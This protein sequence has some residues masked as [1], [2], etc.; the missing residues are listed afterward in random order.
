MPLL[1]SRGE[2][3]D[4]ESWVGF[5]PFLLYGLEVLGNH[6]LD[7]HWLS[8]GKAGTGTWIVHPSVQVPLTAVD[9]PAWWH[10]EAAGE[11]KGL[12]ACAWDTVAT[13]CMH[14]SS[15]PWLLWMKPRT[16]VMS[17]GSHCRH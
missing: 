16:C 8:Y 7:G 3:G 6:W 2:E 17:R 1:T 11:G 12:I 5:V 4:G 9:C 10:L 15:S 14:S 13:T